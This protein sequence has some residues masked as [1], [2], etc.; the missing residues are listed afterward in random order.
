[1]RS[2]VDRLPE[3]STSVVVNKNSKKYYLQGCPGYSQVW[4]KK[5]VI[6]KSVAKAE[7]AGY[8]KA[9]NCKK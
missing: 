8:V 6:F 3:H 5:R 4:E 1:M 9:G 7:A 2:P